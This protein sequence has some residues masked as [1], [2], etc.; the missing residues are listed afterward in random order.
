MRRR[1]RVMLAA[2]ALAAVAAHCVAVAEPADRRLITFD[3][4]HNALTD[5]VTE[6]ANEAV[7]TANNIVSALTSSVLG[8]VTRT[9]SND[10][11]T[12]PSIS[13]TI[14]GD[15]TSDEDEAAEKPTT[16]GEESKE[17]SFNDD[18]TTPTT[19]ATSETATP[20]R[21]SVTVSVSGGEDDGTNYH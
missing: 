3:E 12:S 9:D 15:S 1:R 21:V 19:I 17:E 18:D 13:V 7:D 10:P 11:T 5:T 16:G 4:T 2:G 20:S 8:G 14:G 6:V